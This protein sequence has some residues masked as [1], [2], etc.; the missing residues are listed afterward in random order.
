MTHTV[1]IESARA[2][3]L[4]GLLRELRSDGLFGEVVEMGRRFRLFVDGEA[5]AEP[6]ALMAVEHAVERWLD[7][8]HVEL[9]AQ[10][11][12]DDSLVLRPAA[13]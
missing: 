10:R 2:V 6:V 3:D 11:I 9:L 8:H 7:E 5:D 12:G 4:H 1:E 13:A